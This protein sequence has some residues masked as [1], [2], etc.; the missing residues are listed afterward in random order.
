MDSWGVEKRLG[1]G[2][3]NLSGSADVPKLSKIFITQK[4]MRTFQGIALRRRLR[5][6]IM[7]P[8]PDEEEYY[9]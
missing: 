9:E 4:E 6:S 1:N 3:K 8:I 5:S 7:M 2:A